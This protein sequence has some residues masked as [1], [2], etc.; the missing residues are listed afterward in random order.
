MHRYPIH[1]H[2]VPA[3]L[4]CPLHTLPVTTKSSLFVTDSEQAEFFIKKGLLMDDF[5]HAVAP[6]IKMFITHKALTVFITSHQTQS[7]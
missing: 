7:S 2:R 4:A 5:K 3:H 1:E 6:A